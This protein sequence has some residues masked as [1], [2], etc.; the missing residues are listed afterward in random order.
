MNSWVSSFTSGALAAIVSGLVLAY[1][2]SDK[3]PGPK[4]PDLSLVSQVTRVPAQ[5]IP[6]DL[7]SKL[8]D[9]NKNENLARLFDYASYGVVVAQFEVIN[10][11]DVVLR[12]VEVDIQDAQAIFQNFPGSIKQFDTPNVKLTIPPGERVRLVALNNYSEPSA[13]ATYGNDYYKAQ[14]AYLYGVRTGA[15][16]ASAA[17]EKRYWLVDAALITGMQFA[18]LSLAAFAAVGFAP[19][20]IHRFRSRKSL[21][22][23]PIQA[24]IAKAD[25]I[26][27]QP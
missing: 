18:L 24:P 2:I 25:E 23:N 19:S 3:A 13:S 15:D 10:R 1:A 17:I 11:S 12:D 22:V 27:K 20:V 9:S 8:D 4:K 16:E 21:A 26:E 6:Y 7:R 5:P 14:D